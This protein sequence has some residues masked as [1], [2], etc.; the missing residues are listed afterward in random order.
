MFID[1]FCTVLFYMLDTKRRTTRSA[2]RIV[3]EEEAVQQSAL[4]ELFL[5]CDI[6][7]CECNDN[8]PT[9][10]SLA[11]HKNERHKMHLLYAC[12]E[13]RTNYVCL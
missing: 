3:A 2:S 6:E 12:E 5:V 1:W 11:Q 8:F 10:E 13:C 4:E 7:G 9:L